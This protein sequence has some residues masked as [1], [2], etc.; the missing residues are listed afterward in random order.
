M[1]NVFYH[2]IR[3]PT[4]ISVLTAVFFSYIIFLAVYKIFDPPKIGSAY[5]MILEML[6]IVSIVPLGLFIIDRLLVIKINNIKLT[7]MEAIVLGGISLYYF[8]VVNP[9]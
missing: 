7:I 9:F 6:V 3:K 5:N 8:L 4:F 2:L 1:R